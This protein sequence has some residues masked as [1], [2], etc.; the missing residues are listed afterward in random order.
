MSAESCII[1]NVKHGQAVASGYLGA[2]V[3]TQIVDTERASSLTTEARMLRSPTGRVVVLGHLQVTGTI[4]VRTEKE[5]AGDDKGGKTA[6]EKGK[7]S[8][9]STP[10]TSLLEVGESTTAK[11]KATT[12]NP[13]RWYLFSSEDFTT[14][15]AG[16]GGEDA[17]KDHPV[18]GWVAVEKNK[19]WVKAPTSH[20]GND[21]MFLGGHCQASR[22]VCPGRS[23]VL[24][25]VCVCMGRGE[26]GV[27][28]WGWGEV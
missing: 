22:C 14:V 12:R 24:R 23:G 21:N 9:P 28:G 4:R 27:G 13:H 1:A 8:M 26:W 25:C 19:P 16:A 15:P 20:C 7:D 10:Y 3:D 5:D 6:G 11:A 17:V 18:Q 2:D